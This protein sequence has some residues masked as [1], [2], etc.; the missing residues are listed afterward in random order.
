LCYAPVALVTDYDAWKAGEEVSAGLVVK[1]L[2]HNI[3]DAKKL[4][5]TAIPALAAERRGC[6]C[7]TAMKGAVFTGHKDISAKDEARLRLILE[8]TR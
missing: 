3:I 6:S 4:L 1:T 8:G 2:E 5:E 7:L